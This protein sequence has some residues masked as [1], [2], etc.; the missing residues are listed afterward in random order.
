MN[1][2]L[3]GFSDREDCGIVTRFDP[4]AV[5]L[6]RE[7]DLGQVIDVK[8]VT[9]V[10]DA[11]D[12]RLWLPTGTATKRPVLREHVAG[13]PRVW[14]DDNWDLVDS[15]WSWANLLIVIRPGQHRATWLVWDDDGEFRGWYVNLQSELRRTPFGFDFRDH[16]LDIVVRP[17]RTWHLKDVEEL[18]A[19]VVTNRLMPAEADAIR[20]E[21][22]LAILE[23]GDRGGVFAYA[24]TT[25]PPSGIRRPTMTDQWNDLSMYD[26]ADESSLG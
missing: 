3:G 21:A 26:V 15:V 7:I 23:I 8:P 17:D 10:Q 4:G 13:T 1:E 24:D 25:R 19:A 9:V 12:I 20:S 16:Q 18:E 11:A 5:I 2:I 14:T 6:Y 22:D